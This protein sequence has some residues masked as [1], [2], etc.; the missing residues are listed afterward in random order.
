[1]SIVYGL[2][3][4]VLGCLAVPHLVI[5]KYAG[6]EKIL[7]KLRPFQGWI[8]F[9]SGLWGLYEIVWLLSALTF[10]RGGVRG[11]VYFL[12]I[13]AAVLCQIVL[14]FILGIGI[15][16]SF[17]RDAQ[18]QAKM[19]QLL[20]RVLPYQVMLGILAIVDGA[21]L[22]ITTIVPSLLGPGA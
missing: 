21:T 13:L 3:L 17:V 9:L 5:S 7:N 1:M 12:I 16:K 20:D 2:W 18:A 22:V 11:I 4:F 8:G 14:G 19:E 15:V 6:A 10:L